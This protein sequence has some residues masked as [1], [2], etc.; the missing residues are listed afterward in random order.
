MQRAHYKY[1]FSLH[2]VIFLWGFTGILGRLIRISS[3]SIV[4]WRM[5]I[6]LV[7]L[8]IFMCITRRSF[9]TSWKNRLK[10]LATGLVVAAHWIFFFEAL[11]V[12]NVSITLTTLASTSLLVAFL[13]PLLFKRRVIWYEILFGLLTVG[14][15][16][17]IFQFET[18]FALGMILALIAAFL[19]AVFG[20]VNGLFIRQDRPTLITTME[21]S[22]GMLGITAYYAVAG[23][24]S[25]F[26]I[27]VGIDWIYLLILGLICTSLAFVVSVGVMKELSPFTVSISINIEPIYAIILALIIFKEDEYMS[28]GFYLGAVIVMSTILMNNYFKKRIGLSK[29]EFPSESFRDLSSGS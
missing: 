12:S 9:Q 29:Q 24:F 23:H 6:A 17:L 2:S 18:R 10:Y 3:T 13:E 5:S 7:G 14:G 27:P 21:M 20:T 28:S 25:E 19:A 22:G 4:W 1:Y 26:Q 11:K 16:A 8:L 15:L